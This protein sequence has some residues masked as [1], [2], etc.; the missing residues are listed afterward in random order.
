[1][2]LVFKEHIAWKIETNLQTASLPPAIQKKKKNPK[3]NSIVYNIRDPGVVSPIWKS[4][5]H[6]RYYT[7]DN[8]RFRTTACDWNSQ[9]RCIY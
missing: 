9:G 6:E 4:I 5:G 8:H 7:L 3:T 1:M 2:Y